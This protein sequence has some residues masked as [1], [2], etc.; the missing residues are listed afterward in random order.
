M[1]FNGLHHLPVL[2]PVQAR[3]V[4][5][6]M[7]SS[8]HERDAFF[9]WRPL[10][11][12]LISAAH[13]AHPHRLSSERG[14]AMLLFAVVLAELSGAQATLGLLENPVRWLGQAGLTPKHTSSLWRPRKARAGGGA[15]W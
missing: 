11:E 12:A 7:G 10:P 6:Q 4:F 5:I 14:R 3:H 1:R 15:V 8:L 2:C 9:H 13:L